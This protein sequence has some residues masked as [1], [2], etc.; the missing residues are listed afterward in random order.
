MV[1]ISVHW[2]PFADRKNR[3]S[4]R[5]RIII[6]GMISVLWRSFADRSP[7]QDAPTQSASAMT[8]NATGAPATDILGVERPQG[9]GV[10]MGAYEQ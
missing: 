6:V 1:M 7:L 4:T 5:I 10:D 9:A 2:R 8:W 3:G